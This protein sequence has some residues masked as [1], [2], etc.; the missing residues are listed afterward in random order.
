MKTT[1]P[2]SSTLRHLPFVFLTTF[3]G[4]LAVVSARA[5]THWGNALSFNGTNS[6]VSFGATPPL[7]PPWTAEFWIN[8]Q[9]STNIAATLLDDGITSLRLEQFNGTKLVGFTKYSA[10]DYTFNYT[11]PT[12]TWV[13]LA[14]VSDTTATRLYVNGVAQSTNSN[15]ISLPLRQFGAITNGSGPRCAFKGTVDEIRVWNV[16]R[17]AEDILAEM[18]QPLTNTPAGLVAYWKFDEGSGSTVSD[19]TTNH[20]NGSLVN[21]PEWVVSTVPIPFNYTTNNGTITITKY[22][23]PGGAV[24]V[25]SAI[26]GLPVA[27]IGDSAFA[28]CD[29][30]T[31]VTISYGVTRI[32]VESFFVCNSL[33]NVTIPDSITS[34]GDSAFYICPSLTSVTIPSSVTSIGGNAF[35]VCTS[36]MSINVDTNNPAYSSV[37]GVLFDKSQVTVIEFPGGRGGSY[38]IPGSVSS[39]AAYGF[40]DCRNLVNVIIPDSVTSIGYY[41]F[42]LCTGLTNFMIPAGL[43]SIGSGV[44]EDCFSLKSITV[45]TNNPAYSSVDGVLFDKSQVTIITFPGGRGGNYTIPDSVT[46]IGDDAFFYCTG[47]TNVII[48]NGVT[49]IGNSAFYCCAGLTSL[50]IPKNVTSIGWSAFNGCDNLISITI[51]NSVTNIESYAFCNCDSLTG[52]YFQGDAPSLGVSVFVNDS[53]VTVYRLPGTTDWAAFDANSGLNPAVLW[54]A[55]VQTADGNFGVRTNQFGFTIAGTADIPIVVEA[56]TNLACPAWTPLQTCCVTNGSIYFGDAEWT[57]HLGR[58]YRVRWP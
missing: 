3:I 18:V 8:R 45:D 49:R 54:N 10:A 43:T 16:V 24:I 12:N 30:V 50:P 23:G 13:H 31:S 1:H 17:S 57:N 56:C 41:A 58:F 4:C 21:T 37:D 53:N 48:P 7:S 25:P 15:T 51:P 20:C 33:T 32:G 40:Y 19:A 39:I 55:Q 46:R 2:L 38:S 14:F 35:I 44:F 47:L 22:T 27:T 5:Q 52:I 29:T 28:Y 26:N 36:L 6:Y 11:A 42:A 34:I 9:D